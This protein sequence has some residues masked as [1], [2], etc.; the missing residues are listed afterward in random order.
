MVASRQ[1]NS[2]MN[3]LV[4]SGID[5]SGKTTVI[6]EVRAHLSNK[7]IKTFYIWL[8]FN[9][10]FCKVMH[11]LARFLKLSVKK[12]SYRGQSWF[13]EFYRSE[14]F[15]ALYIRMT[16]VDTVIG[17]LKFRFRL[18]SNINAQYIICDRWV[19]DVLVDLAVKTHREDFLDTIWYHRFMNLMPRNATKILIVRNTN[20]L[21]SCREE[22]AEDPDFVFRN[23]LYQK[24]QQKPE[25]NVIDNN[26]SIDSTVKSFLRV[27]NLE[28]Y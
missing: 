15:C 3:Y 9:H 14:L 25:I 6:E 2:T 19:P 10:Y 20:E 17:Y 16:Y 28:K 21:V 24:L 1:G 13:H 22:N 26:G 5:G 4:I 11:A 23:R 27:A 7:C 12:P 8:R 18:F